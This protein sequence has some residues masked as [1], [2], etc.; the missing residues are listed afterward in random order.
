MV[1]MIPC[2]GCGQQYSV[3]A[4]LAGKQVKCRKCS[5]S[6]RVPVP[7]MSS[8]LESPAMA[9]LL[10]EDLLGQSFD[11]AAGTTP[12]P[13]AGG[14]ATLAPL[15]RRRRPGGGGRPL[16]LIGL[17][18]GGV[19]V[20]VGFVVAVVLV[21]RAVTPL[22]PDRAMRDMIASLDKIGDALSNV[23]DEASAKVAAKKIKAVMDRQKGRDEQ[24]KKLVTEM[25]DEEK[26]RLG[27]K[28]QEKIKVVTQRLFD[29]LKRVG[30]IQEARGPLE[31]VLKGSGAM[32]S[33]FRSLSARKG[34][35][36]PLGSRLG[37]PLGSRP[38]APRPEN[39]PEPGPS[40]Q[41][42][43]IWNA[44]SGGLGGSM[45]YTLEY[46]L[47]S[48]KP[49]PGVRY[50]WVIEL[51]SGGRV[52]FPVSSFKLKNRGTLR[53]VGI[54]AG[55]G[56]LSGPSGAP[57]GQSRTYV[58]M[59][60][61]VGGRRRISN[62]IRVVSPGRSGAAMSSGALTEEQ[63][64]E[65]RRRQQQRVEEMI[66]EH[67]AEKVVVVR[68]YNIPSIARTYIF[69]RLKELSGSSGVSQ[70]GGIGSQD[71]TLA[72]VSDI[73]ALA[74]KLDFGEV[75]EVDTQK[76]VITIKVDHSKLPEKFRPLV[77]NPRDPRF[78]K[79]NLA[80]L[81]GPDKQRSRQALANVKKAEPK[82]LREEIAKAV[83]SFLLDEDQIMRRDALEAF[84]AWS[85]S[86][87]VP[88]LIQALEDESSFVRDV[89]IPALAK[90]K[91]ERAV[92]PLV[93]RFADDHY[94]VAQYLKSMGSVAEKAVAEFLTHEDL[95]VRR[96]AVGIL[97]EIGTK[98]T[99]AGLIKL[100]DEE[101]IS[102]RGDALDA[103]IKLKDQQALERI[104]KMLPEE[105]FKVSKYLKSMG[106]VAEKAVAKHLEHEDFSVRRE[107]AGVL[108]EIGTK[109]TVP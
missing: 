79:E 22:T 13:P 56:A 81:T 103:L 54:G 48:L 6:F 67:G 32:S 99:A 78:Y 35:D 28:Y 83:K 5:R 23:K 93:E 66:K 75:S 98:E 20:V 68:V 72:P 36:R 82:E 58:E 61:G 1:D 91:D 89:A 102:I 4:E 88:V 2:P 74:A 40:G 71:F 101:D 30:E 105:R 18:A 69:S 27:E 10:D 73:K 85:T 31:D 12:F 49:K 3:T 59:G 106:S 33:R 9:D 104:A 41:P 65:I 97:K 45:S 16:L 108:K 76:R 87:V 109:E 92:E 38:S 7:S 95:R 63:R 43:T 62:T 60:T 24:M 51:A 80:A 100:L 8:G 21:V 15:P 39:I 29:E 96:S 84:V 57:Q 11:P 37:G 26:K 64:E 19:V 50:I 44:R 17:L 86:D 90:T 107:A 55:M 94:R 34:R 52:E 46:R 25:S 14:P 53:G 47:D 42:V 77:S 70:R